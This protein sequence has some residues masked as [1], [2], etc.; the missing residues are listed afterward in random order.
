MTESEVGLSAIAVG[1]WTVPKT[2]V[3][4]PETGFLS[5]SDEGHEGTLGMNATAVGTWSLSEASEAEV[6]LAA[7]AEGSWSLPEEDEAK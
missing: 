1:E 7:T 5:T 3:A 6:D 4:Q 2:V